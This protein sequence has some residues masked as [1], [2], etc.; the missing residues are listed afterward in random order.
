M[1]RKKK[2]L[3]FSLI[4]NLINGTHWNELLTRTLLLISELG[5]ISIRAARFLKDNWEITVSETNLI[6]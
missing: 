4:I 3:I 6:V 2:T 1:E 5:D